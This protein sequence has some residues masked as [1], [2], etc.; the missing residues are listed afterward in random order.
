VWPA[1]FHA[2]ALL[3]SASCILA[4]GMATT[5]AHRH[6]RLERK[7]A[8]RRARRPRAVYAHNTLSE[9][10]RQR[11]RRRASRLRRLSRRRADDAGV[12]RDEGARAV[13]RFYAELSK[14][15]RAHVAEGRE[16]RKARD[17]ER[18]AKGHGCYRP[19]P[20]SEVVS[21][22]IKLKGGGVRPRPKLPENVGQRERLRGLPQAVRRAFKRQRQ[23][24]AS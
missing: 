1:G 5:E 14:V 11:T 19:S 24:R 6:A 3:S 4:R 23:P 9:K 15:I 22:E 7:R 8:R 13:E 2:R 18:S 21:T 12:L 17:E 16:K 10:E 20:L